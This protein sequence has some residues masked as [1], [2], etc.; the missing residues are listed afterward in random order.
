MAFSATISVSFDRS[1]VVLSDCTFLNVQGCK[2]VHSALNWFLGHFSAIHLLYLPGAGLPL[3]DGFTSR[4]CALVHNETSLHS[5]CYTY[6]MMKAASLFGFVAGVHWF[7]LIVA[8]TVTVTVRTPVGCSA[9][10]RA[11]FSGNA[12][13]ITTSIPGVSIASPLSV[14]SYLPPTEARSPIIL[15][16]ATA[17]NGCEYQYAACLQV[18]DNL[19]PLMFVQTEEL[20][21]EYCATFC[22]NHDYFGVQQGKTRFQC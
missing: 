13:V 14:P 22:A 19:K 2:V 4:L 16:S 20:T 8:A 18:N 7:I 10:D 6:V 1:S 12:Q 5:Y 3:L 21:I 17:S 15:P 9:G 11:T